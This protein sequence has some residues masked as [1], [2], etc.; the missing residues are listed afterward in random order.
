MS[1]KHNQ[2]LNIIIIPQKKVLPFSEMDWLMCQIATILLLPLVAIYNHIKTI[3]GLKVR[4]FQRQFI[5]FGNFCI[6]LLGRMV[7]GL[8]RL[9]PMD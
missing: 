8:A 9:K 4:S 5:Y 3:S 2:E 6:Q 1:T 7:K